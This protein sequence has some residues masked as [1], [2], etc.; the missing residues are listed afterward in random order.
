MS[1]PDVIVRGGAGRARR[2][3]R[4]VAAGSRTGAV[5]L[6]GEFTRETPAPF[7]QLPDDCT[8][9]T[10][11]VVARK[12]RL[13][14]FGLPL[15]GVACMESVQRELDEAAQRRACRLAHAA[16]PGVRVEH[17]VVRSWRELARHARGHAYDAV[18]V[19]DAPRWTIDRV[20]AWAARRRPGP[21][22]TP[23]IA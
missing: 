15:C 19:A 16:P 3:T 5:L 22:A 23:R 8:R 12:P 1:F 4:R 2:A 21:L 7:E 11:A 6:A 13:L 9:L 20:F 10:I 18:L 14:C 17:V